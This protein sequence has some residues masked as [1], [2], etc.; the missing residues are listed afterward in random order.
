MSTESAVFARLGVQELRRVLFP[1]V[2]M[3]SYDVFVNLTI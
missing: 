1:C 3:L 2:L